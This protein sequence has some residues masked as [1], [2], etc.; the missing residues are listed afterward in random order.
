MAIWLLERII[1]SFTSDQFHDSNPRGL[2][3]GNLTSQL[4]A[5]IYLN[6]FDRF[7]KH[8]LKIEHYV[9]YTDDFVIVSGSLDYLQAV[10]KLSE[11]FLNSNLALKLH[12]KKITVR[13]ASQGIDFLGYI[14]LPD[15]RLL[16]VKTKKRI[17]TK[18]EERVREFKA[19]V[20]A[21]Y[22]FNS[23]SN[24]IL[25]FCLMQIHIG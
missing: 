19:G 15:Y 4:F 16:R 13:K 8:T 5:N 11:H 20:I 23:R 17:F 14:V 1:E 25:E 10:L 21:G 12:P 6:E 3:I 22:L 7:V 2:P 24:H 9:R 18:M